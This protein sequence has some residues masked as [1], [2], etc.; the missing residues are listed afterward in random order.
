MSTISNVLRALEPWGFGLDGVE[1]KLRSDKLDEHA[2]IFRRTKPVSPAMSMAVF[3]NKIFISAENLDWEGA[4]DFITAVNAG[5]DAVKEGVNPVVQSQ[6]LVLGIHIQLKDKPRVDVMKPL[7]N[8]KALGLLDSGLKF[9]GVIV[10]GE[11]LN[12]II[13][14]SVVYANGLW[15]RLFRDHVGNATLHDVAQ[16]LRADEE[17]LFDVLGLEGIL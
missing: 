12:V 7:I 13:E 5:I 4:E 15:V 11:S 9:P 6:Q 3:Y 2:V 14:A 1:T 8:P 16:K 17:R 10:T